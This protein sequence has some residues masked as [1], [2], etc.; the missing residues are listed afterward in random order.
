MRAF[1]LEQF[2]YVLEDERKLPKEEQTIFIL[3]PLTASENRHLQNAM[4]QK[5]EGGSGSTL[6]PGTGQYLALK[7]G[8][9]GWKNLK[10]ADDPEVQIE[11]EID[12]G[13]RSPL[14]KALQGTPADEMFDHIVPASMEL[15]N[16]IIDG[17]DLT[18]EDA[19]N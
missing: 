5:F 15:A 7:A 11:F 16:T 4:V 18:K 19:K 6:N 3:R 8:L 17:N 14:G 1:K 12:K 10:H 2:E 13:T 9:R